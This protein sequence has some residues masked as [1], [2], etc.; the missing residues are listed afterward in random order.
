MHKMILVAAAAA[1]AGCSQ[2]PAAE[3]ANDADASL[4]ANAVDA[5]AAGTASSRGIR[6][7]VANPSATV[8]ISPDLPSLSTSFVRIT[9]T[10]SNPPRAA[11]SGLS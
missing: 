8:F 5:N 6:K 3:P 9:F 1:L 10:R 2:Q 7:L 4:E 11:W